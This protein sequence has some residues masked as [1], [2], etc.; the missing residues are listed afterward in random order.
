MMDT[1]ELSEEH[2]EKLL[3]SIRKLVKTSSKICLTHIDKF[4][5]VNISLKKCFFFLEIVMSL[6]SRRHFL[7]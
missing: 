3:V 7:I 2:R 5:F 1:L 4:A 6:L